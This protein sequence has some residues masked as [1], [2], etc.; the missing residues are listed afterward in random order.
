MVIKKKKKKK[1]KKTK[2]QKDS[3]M[4]IKKEKEK[5]IPQWLETTFPSS[6]PSRLNSFFLFFFHKD[7]PSIS[8]SLSQQPYLYLGNKR[9]KIPCV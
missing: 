5:R 3:T 8:Y 6:F 1:T 7:K 4:V 9:K 2:K